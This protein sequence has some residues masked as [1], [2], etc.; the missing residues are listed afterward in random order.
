MVETKVLTARCDDL[1]GLMLEVEGY[2]V[3]V[4]LSHWG[5]VP[6]RLDF[7]GCSF[8]PGAEERLEDLRWASR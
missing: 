4:R 1:G 7:S 8:G 2:E 6:A 5:D 3:E